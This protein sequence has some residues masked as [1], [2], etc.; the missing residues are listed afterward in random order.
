[1]EAIWRIGWGEV[2][3]RQVVA[4]ATTWFCRQI[5]PFLLL[6]MT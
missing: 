1:M 5:R 6:A 2:V 3:A 4:V